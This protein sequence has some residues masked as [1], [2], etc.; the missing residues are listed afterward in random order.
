M[1]FH[2]YF[3]VK[4]YE[5][6]FFMFFGQKDKTLPLFFTFTLSTMLT[7]LWVAFIQG[8]YVWMGWNLSHYLQFLIQELTFKLIEHYAYLSLSS[9]QTRPLCLGELESFSLSPAFDTGVNFQTDRTLC[10]PFFEQ[11]PY[12][13]TM[14]GWGGIFLIISSV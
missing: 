1:S 2:T 8:R 13:A 7:F 11:H 5:F 9:I 6:L 3:V 12:K 10:L 4:K 14:F